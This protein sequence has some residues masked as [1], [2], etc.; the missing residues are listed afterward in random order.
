MSKNTGAS[1]LLSFSMK[2]R[3]DVFEWGGGGRVDEK[4]VDL[5]I[6]VYSHCHGQ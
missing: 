4:H 2:K 3:V 5:N 6:R 1:C